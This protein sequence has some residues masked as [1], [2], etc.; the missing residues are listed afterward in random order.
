MNTKINVQKNYLKNL[1]NLIKKKMSDVTISSFIV[2]LDVIHPTLDIATLQDYIKNNFKKDFIF[3]NA[4]DYVDSSGGR[5]SR[6]DSRSDKRPK[7]DYSTSISKGLKSKMES[8]ISKL[9]E[10]KKK[11]LAQQEKLKA[12]ESK[13]SSAKQLP[14]APILYGGQV[15]AVFC[16]LNYPYTSLQLKRLYEGGVDLGAFITMK[17]SGNLN[18]IADQVKNKTFEKSAR[19]LAKRQLIEGSDMDS[20]LNPGVFPPL[21]WEQLKEDCAPTTVFSSIDIGDTVEE[22][23]QSLEKE[24]GTIIRCRTKFKETFKDRVFKSLP[25]AN[26]RIDYTE[27]NNFLQHY[28]GNV[29]PAIMYMLLEGGGIKE[30]VEIPPP[31]LKDQYEN[32][33]ADGLKMLDRS[34]S[35]NKE[36]K[37]VNNESEIDFELTIP[38]L[39]SIYDVLYKLIK[40]E[41]NLELCYA[42]RAVMKF[43]D[44]N[45]QFYCAAGHQFDVMVA[46]ANKKF[47]LGLPSSFYD[48]QKWAYYKEYDNCMQELE[49]AVQSSNYV[50]TYLEE[51]P[52]ILWVL[53]MT[54]ISKLVGFTVKKYYMPQMIDGV[55]QWYKY[56]FDKVVEVEKKSSRSKET[57]ADIIRHGKMKSLLT[58]IE[59]RLDSEQHDIYRLSIEYSDTVS[60]I[61]PYLFID[62]FR[63]DVD[64]TIY[65]RYPTFNVTARFKNGLLL[66]TNGSNSNIITKT[67]RIQMDDEH[68]I[69]IFQENSSIYY[70]YGKLVLKISNDNDYLITEDG[71]LI[72][73]DLDKIKT[74]IGKKGLIGRFINNNWNWTN[75]K[76]Q[77]YTKTESKLECNNEKI[78]P[79]TD[80]YTK[81]TKYVRN[82][83][84]N[85]EEYDD[86]TII[87]R[88]DDE[89][90]IRFS[91]NSTNF[92]IPNFPNI[93]VKKQTFSFQVGDISFNLGENSIN[94]ASPEFTAT[95][96]GEN[97]SLTSEKTIVNIT[98]KAVQFRSG[99]EVL[100]TTPN[101]IERFGTIQPPDMKVNKKLQVITSLWGNIIP[102][103]D[104]QTEAR[105]L[106]L[107]KLFCPRFFAVRPGLVATEF[108]HE[109]QL[110]TPEKAMK[111]STNSLQDIEIN[112]VS[113]HKDG[114]K[115]DFYIKQN[116]PDK[117]NRINILKT[118]QVPKHPPKPKSA[119]SARKNEKIESQEEVFEES[120]K[121]RSIFEQNKHRINE[122]AKALADDNEYDYQ[123]EIHPPPVPPEPIPPPAV[124]TPPPSVLIAQA[125]KYAEK[126]NKGEI[127]SYWDSPES[128]FAMPEDPN[129]IVQKPVSPR[130]AMHDLVTPDE[131]SKGNPPDV[132]DDDDDLKMKTRESISLARA[133]LTPSSLSP[134]LTAARMYRTEVMKPALYSQD[135]KYVADFKTLH[136]G[137]TALQFVKVQN[138]SKSQMNF[139]FSQP[140]NPNITVLTPPGVIASGLTLSIKIKFVAKKAEKLR[141]SFNIQTNHGTI[142]IACKAQVVP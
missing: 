41:P 112:V 13:R 136:V 44:D 121:L 38:S 106:D 40:W 139:S 84:F 43:Y 58:P 39:P 131:E 54:P 86:G 130:N 98:P 36:A 99:D 59:T 88:L 10:A 117:Q 101:C 68:D 2:S 76:G 120:N 17:T 104:I 100:Y 42:A 124:F 27:L 18:A 142:P 133:I 30:P 71:E 103:K 127:L 91:D 129:K 31:T 9:T 83:L 21:R 137:D 132:L 138:T 65:A 12:K 114:E 111:E 28:P 11:H 25:Y 110:P 16:I 62:G 95:K 118:L 8:E 75:N 19:T 57:T 55:D 64:R 113:F 90:V 15:E 134:P 141:A 72:F 69:T 115:P 102:L 60:L 108:V 140:S 74:I 79:S 4:T 122:I 1:K 128:T 37:N 61:T 73:I 7:Y 3:L 45:L 77:T 85:L 46:Q 52:G 20:T 47:N 33:F 81:I 87:L 34:V 50:A 135:R 63:A 97:L 6:T 82:D 94:I 51:A 105:L 126:V 5:S 67:C 49:K 32:L 56:I 26:D 125:Q 53:T 48:W 89:F 93:T 22:M 70:A 80:Y 109:S 14:E 107:H 92:Q 35:F 123:L 78:L 23:W 119:R 66:T 29:Y 24:I 116:M 96:N